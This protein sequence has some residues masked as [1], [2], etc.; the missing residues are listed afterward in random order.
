MNHLKSLV[1]KQNH[2]VRC[3]FWNR[4]SVVSGGSVSGSFGTDK[5]PFAVTLPSKALKYFIISLQ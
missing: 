2:S 4:Y 1:S 3:H 5:Q